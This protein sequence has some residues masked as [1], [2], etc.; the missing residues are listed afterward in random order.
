M[1]NI[2]FFTPSLNIGGI[3]KVF[4]SYAEKLID[5]GYNVKYVVTHN[6]GD[7]LKNLPEKIEVTVLGGRGLKYS[8]F[9]IIKYLR[10]EEPDVIITGG[11]IPNLVF[12]IIIKL[13]RIKSKLIVSHHN[14]HNIER[15]QFL[16]KIIIKYFYNYTTKVVAVSQ[17][18]KNLLLEGGVNE[19]KIITIYN[20]I[21]IAK[22]KRQSVE[23]NN[24]SLPKDYLVFIGRLGKVKNLDLLIDSFNLLK[25]KNKE[26]E[27]VIIGEGPMRNNL[28]QKVEKLNLTKYVRFLGALANPY[29]ILKRS[30]VVVLSSFSEALPTIILESFVL[31]K[32]VVSTPTG[33]AKDLL[34]ENK[35]G[36][37]SKSFKEEEFCKTIERA[38]L[39]PISNKLLN[40]KA[41]TFDIE[42]KVNE[43]IVFF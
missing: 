9:L 21:N 7:L 10:K 6:D 15:N 18:I 28:E 39:S 34:G 37:I 25:Q 30:S 41:K 22:I 17:G 27:L 11:E 5:K 13:F 3:E 1:K 33:G 32:T 2:L 42:L 14:Y 29:S 20:P 16:S 38:I 35:F 4:I 23:N 12:I 43:L 40:E 26:I 19:S 8:I 36:Y 31:S 24:I